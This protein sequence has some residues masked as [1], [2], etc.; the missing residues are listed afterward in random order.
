MRRAAY[1][2]LLLDDA[3][4]AEHAEV[5]VA[6]E[7]ALEEAARQAGELAVGVV[8]AEPRFR[9]GDGGLADL[10]KEFAVLEEAD[11]LDLRDRP[12][13][14][15]EAR[16]ATLE[17]RRGVQVGPGAEE[18]RV[19]V[20]VRAAGHCADAADRVVVK[21]HLERRV[22]PVPPA[23]RSSPTRV[24]APLECALDMRATTRS[25]GYAATRWPGDAPYYGVAVSVLVNRAETTVARIPFWIFRQCRD[26][27]AVEGQRD[28][29]VL[30]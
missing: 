13:E 19:G 2:A 10:E 25:E 24:I 5:G 30:A 6:A 23:M 28:E 14:H 16:D 15:S 4:H 9:H 18:Q 21:V 17:E 8:H 26:H 29:R 27:P 12:T 3:G 7:G 22:D 20:G 1:H 11:Q